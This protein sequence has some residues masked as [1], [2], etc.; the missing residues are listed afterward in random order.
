MKVTVDSRIFELLIQ[1][2]NEAY[3]VTHPISGTDRANAM[4]RLFSAVD[5]YGAYITSQIEKEAQRAGPG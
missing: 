2:A 4:E 1:I 5:E 3:G